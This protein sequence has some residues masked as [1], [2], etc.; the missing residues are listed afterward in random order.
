MADVKYAPPNIEKG[1]CKGTVE[2]TI[3]SFLDATTKA[4][5]VAL[6]AEIVSKESEACAACLFSMD[7][8]AK[9]APVVEEASGGITVNIGGC[10]GIVSGKEACGKPPT[11]GTVASTPS[12]PSASR[13]RRAAATRVRAG[14]VVQPRRACEQG[15]SCSRDAQQ[16]ACKEATDMLGTECGANANAYLTSCQ[17]LYRAIQMQCIDDGSADTGPDAN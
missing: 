10:V 9:W 3:K 15:S 6:E 13:A 4:T 12:A 16:T 17:T 8:D 7:A 5:W 14:L 2:Q 1:A 11:C